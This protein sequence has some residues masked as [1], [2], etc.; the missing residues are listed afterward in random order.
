MNSAHTKAPWF[1]TTDSKFTAEL[2]VDANVD[3]QVV[4]IALIH[5]VGTDEET[6]ANAALIVTAPALVREI[7]SA[8]DMF[9]EIAKECAHCNYG[10]GATGLSSDGE[11]ACEECAPVR[12]AERRARATV[13]AARG[14]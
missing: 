3:G 11:S 8:A 7:E 10:E 9:C 6:Q 14:K 13:A 2:A 1:V 4:H 5:G 12:D